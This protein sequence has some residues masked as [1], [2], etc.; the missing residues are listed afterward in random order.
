MVVAVV[1]V[2]LAVAVAVV[3]VTGQQLVLDGGGGWLVM[4]DLLVFI[5]M[6]NILTADYC[7]ATQKIGLHAILL[8]SCSI[9]C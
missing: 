9:N 6:Q 5:K 4:A 8:I 7:C 2:A 3:V 1:A